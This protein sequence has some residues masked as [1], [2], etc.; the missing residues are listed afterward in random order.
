MTYRF[1]MV[2][3]VLLYRGL[4]AL[5]GLRVGGSE[6]RVAPMSCEDVVGTL[7]CLVLHA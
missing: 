2:S 4:H 1:Y 3:G 7:E 5:E 6:L